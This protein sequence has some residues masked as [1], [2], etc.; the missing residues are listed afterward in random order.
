MSAPGLHGF[1]L[2]LSLIAAIGAQNAYVLR[3]GVAR[4]HVGAVAALCIASDAVLMSAGTA[5][6]GALVTARPGLLAAVTGVG[7]AFLIGY[8]ALALRGAV[9]GIRA[10]RAGAA[11][12]LAAD[13][14]AGAGGLGAALAGAAAVTW[15]NPHAYLDTVV[16]VG[17]VAAAQGPDRWVFTA[18]AVAASATWFTALAAGARAAAPWLARP[19]AWVAVDALTGVVMLLLA[20]RIGAGLWW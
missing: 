10:L 13:A 16:F 5:G 4:R 2:A 19:R 3:A 9:R 17:S 11:A 7:V 1:V 15:L 12:G 6:F 14:G 20:W 8:G 18:G